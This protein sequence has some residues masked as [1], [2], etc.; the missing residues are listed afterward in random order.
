MDALNVH[1]VE[2][3]RMLYTSDNVN[4]LYFTMCLHTYGFDYFVYYFIS[5]LLSAFH[6]HK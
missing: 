4:L 1:A 5:L 6:P 2:Q 3:T